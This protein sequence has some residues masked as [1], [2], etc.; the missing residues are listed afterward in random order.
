VSVET[1]QAAFRGRYLAFGLT[2]L[3]YATYYFGRKGISVSKKTIA[4]QLGEGVLVGVDTVYL[5]A[6]AIGQA[7][8]GYWGDRIGA[9]RLI[10][11]GMLLSAGCCA[12]FGAGSLAVIFLIAFGVNGLAQS[13]GWPGNVKAM[14]EWTPPAERGA[15]MG[16][17]ATCYQAGGIAATA[18]AAIMLRQYGWRAAF[19]GPALVLLVVGVLVI[20]LLKPG[21]LA[22]SIS[23]TST[24][25]EIAAHREERKLAQRHVLRQPIVYFYGASY[26]FIKLIRYSLLFWLPYYLETSLGYSSYWAGMASTSF[27]AGGI[28]GT[29]ALGWVSDRYRGLSR[30]AWSVLSLLGLAVALV[31]Y[32]QLGGIHPFVNVTVMALVGALL[33]GPD[34]LLSGAGAQDAGGARGAA[35]AAGTINAIGS[36]GAVL[37]ELVTRTVSKRFGWNGLFYAFVGFAL[38]AA[39]TLVPTLLHRQKTA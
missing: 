10:G 6:Y 11:F 31:M 7:I 30:S 32:A 20:V 14:A 26:F 18:F 3:S 13:T 16:I 38:L 25:E 9:A 24:A 5:A 33:F 28:L 19:W 36:L 4:S 23:R 2:W 8:S 34:A 17:W 12:A 22:G 27:D 15:V 1:K 29:I 39:L 37:Q 35:I 21:P